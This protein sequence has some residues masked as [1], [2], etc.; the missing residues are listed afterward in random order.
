MKRFVVVG[1]LSLACT[2][3]W[4]AESTSSAAASGVAVLHTKSITPASNVLFQAESTPPSTAQEWE[5]VRASA[6]AL[7]RA[8]QQLASQ[9]PAKDQSQ[10]IN[11]AQALRKQAERAVRAAEKKDQDALVVANGDIVSVCEDCHAKYRD[12]GRNMKE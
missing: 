8:A 3:A 6:A 2:S 10:W 12:A 4:T 5:Q 7:G 9:D 1:L 11:F